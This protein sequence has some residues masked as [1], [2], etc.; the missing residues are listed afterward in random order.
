[1]CGLFITDNSDNS[2]QPSKAPLKIIILVNLVV[3]KKLIHL[4][5]PQLSLKQGYLQLEK[6]K[7]HFFIQAIFPII[8]KASKFLICFELLLLFNSP[9]AQRS[10]K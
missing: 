9:H 1:M 6:L 7:L 5:S 8:G 4:I 3:N 10:S 2:K